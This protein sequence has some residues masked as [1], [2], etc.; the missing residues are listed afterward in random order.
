MVA[1]DKRP[2]GVEKVFAGFLCCPSV[3]KAKDCFNLAGIRKIEIRQKRAKFQ[4]N[5]KSE[6][7][8]NW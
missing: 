8:G 5:V 7:S 3:G 6:S 2:N 1:W 4:T